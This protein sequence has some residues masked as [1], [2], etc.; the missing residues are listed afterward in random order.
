MKR[1]GYYGEEMTKQER[2][3]YQ[4]Y[5]EQWRAKYTP[6]YALRRRKD[7]VHSLA[8]ERVNG[9]VMNTD[10]WYELFDVKFGNILY[11]TPETRARIW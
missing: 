11:L 2:K 10:R 5:A 8:K 7:D 9:T 1:E 3:F 4:A 6:K